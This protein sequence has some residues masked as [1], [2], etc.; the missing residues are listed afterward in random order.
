MLPKPTSSSPGAQNPSTS[1]GLPTTVEGCKNTN[2][3]AC[4]ADEDME[5]DGGEEGD[6]DGDAQEAMQD[7]S[8]QA[9]GRH[10]G[11]RPGL[12]MYC[13][14]LLASILP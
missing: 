14:K 4:R 7:D 13:V 12:E 6:R 5:S 3:W 1:P 8:I 11:E 9:F 10:Q 2:R